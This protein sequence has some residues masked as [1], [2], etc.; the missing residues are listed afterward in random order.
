[1]W[2]GVGRTYI[3]S[4]QLA[5]PHNL[6]KVDEIIRLFLFVRWQ[7]KQLKTI[8]FCVLLPSFFDPQSAGPTKKFPLM[9]A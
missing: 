1:M 5:C 3:F 2:E 7:K 4:K 9:T 8:E 6:V